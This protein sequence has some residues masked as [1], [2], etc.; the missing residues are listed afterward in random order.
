MNNEFF[1]LSFNLLKVRKVVRM[2]VW[3]VVP[4]DRNIVLFFLKESLNQ[5]KNFLFFFFFVAKVF[6]TV[7]KKQK[8]IKVVRLTGE[9]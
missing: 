6:C 8:E 7:C 4:T 1:V 3:M 2:V 9:S 5:K